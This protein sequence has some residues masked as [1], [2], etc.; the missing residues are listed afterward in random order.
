MKKQLQSKNE[1]VFIQ[2]L[3][4]PFYFLFGKLS[5]KKQCALTG[6]LAF[7]GFFSFVG[8]TIGAVTSSPA[9]PIFALLAIVCIV[10]A[11]V[12]GDLGSNNVRIIEKHE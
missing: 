6:V 4:T 10:A 9:T 3:A 7:V 5:N 8:T 1:V 11:C 12:C 2:F